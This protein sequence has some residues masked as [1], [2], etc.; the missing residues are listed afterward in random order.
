VEP[1]SLVWIPSRTAPECTLAV[2]SKIESPS[3]TEDP[4]TH[5]TVGPPRFAS[6]RCQLIGRRLREALVCLTAI[7]VAL[8]PAQFVMAQDPPEAAAADAAVRGTFTVDG[9]PVAG[10]TI[11]IVIDWEPRTG[12]TDAAGAFS[13]AGLPANAGQVQLSAEGPNGEFGYAQVTLAAGQEVT[14]DIAGEGGDVITIRDKRQGTSIAQT[15]IDRQKAAGVEDIIDVAELSKTTASNVADAVQQLPAVT[16]VGGRFAYVR[17]LG[18][19][20]SQTLLDGS[21]L[22]SPEPDRRTV[23]L[24]L[25]PLGM[26]ESVSVAKTYSAELPG[27]FAGG[28]VQATTV[29]VPVG[30][31]VKLSLSGKYADGTSFRRFQ[32]YEGGRLDA[33][34]YDDGTRELPEAVPSVQ[35]T[36]GAG[37]LSP[38]QLAQIGASFDPVWSPHTTTAPLN[39]SISLSLGDRWELGDMMKIGL[40]AAGSYSNS[41]DFTN[42]EQRDLIQQ[43]LGGLNAISTYTIDT[44]SHQ[45]DLAAVVATTFEIS[46][47]QQIT[48]RNLLSRASEDKVVFQTGFDGQN[49]G[50]DV[51]YTRLQW[52]E[53][54][55]ANT[56][57]SGKHLFIGDVL[58]SWRSAASLTERDQPDTR[59]N[60]YVDQDDDGTFEWDTGTNSGIRHFY[61]QSDTVYDLGFD[62]AFPF[63]P[64]EQGDGLAPDPNRLQPGQ[65]IKVGAAATFRDRELDTRKFR[66][67]GDTSGLDLTLPPEEIIN[68]DTILD[69]TF[70]I[71][72]QT[73]PT[74]NYEASQDLTAA[75]VSTSF[76]VRDDFRVAGG[77]RIEKSEQA[78][79]TFDLFGPDVIRAQLDDTDVLPAMNLTWEFDRDEDPTEPGR[80][81]VKQQL[82]LGVS[83]TVS[84]PEFRELAEFEYSDVEGG[85]GVVGNPALERAVLQNYDLRWEWFP[86]D[87]EIVS[88]SLF[89]KTFDSP[90]EQV[91]LPTGGAPL[92]SFDNADSAIL[93]GF[94]LEGR[95]NLGF[96][97]SF[98]EPFTLRGN[99]AW[100]ESEIKIASNPLTLQ[101]SDNRPLQGQPEYTANL[102]LFFED[103][104]SGWTAS[105]LA[106]TF[107]ERIDAVGTGGIPD[108]YEQPRVQLDFIIA[109]RF[110]NRSKLKFTFGNILDDPV[111]IKV[112]SLTQR[113]FELGMSIGVSY[114]IDL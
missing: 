33:F 49:E 82:R 22:P 55:L 87:T 99:F 73:R 94:E 96:L 29:G 102:A 76:R 1:A 95:K 21:S 23:P 3:L 112:G 42:D 17:G 104:T 37:G 41:Y 51:S 77:V 2:P 46:P 34:G 113:K 50:A 47:A 84:R 62:L 14:A 107:G 48:W 114:S 66:F 56:Q 103:E 5:S 32:T 38:G 64:F 9:S 39:G 79:E 6:A 83:Q 108:F 20:Y 85:F 60:K 88:A 75:Y 40:I 52:V 86:T 26:I 13:I 97:G 78:V 31:F 54:L 44:S 100:I 53:R 111:E 70:V 110:A 4:V 18:D 11:S 71:N 89:A 30:R 25:F 36:G 91:K 35:V 8:A 24:D 43:S 61:F 10:A 98:W 74:D 93:Y 72:E 7:C 109:K 45:T 101:T 58:L 90:I 67:I 59:Q 80:Q 68:P 12:T 16:I 65:Y 28:S 57:L 81:K 69:G 27:E 63:N 105:L 106:N 92:T 19:R 15:Q